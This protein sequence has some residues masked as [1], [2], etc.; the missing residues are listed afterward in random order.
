MTT[1]VSRWGLVRGYC[2][3]YESL[4]DMMK[5][6]KVCEFDVWARPMPTHWV[7]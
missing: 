5:I 7:E 2:L 3:L 6:V 4:C 1:W